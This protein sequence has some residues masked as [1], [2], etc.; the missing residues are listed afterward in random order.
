MANKALV[1]FYAR[2]VRKDQIKIEDVDPN[3]RDDVQKVLNEM[4]SE[5][6]K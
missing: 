3:V 1:N 2:L 4:N 5:N 6:N